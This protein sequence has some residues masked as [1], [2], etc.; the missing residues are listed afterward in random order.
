MLLAVKGKEDFLLKTDDGLQ[1]TLVTLP[2]MDR[3]YYERF[4]Y[5]YHPDYS[6]MFADQELTAVAIMTGKYVKLPLLFEHLHYSTGKTPK[7]VINS[8]NDSTWQQGERLFNERLKS[9]FG[10][11]NP[12]I[13]Y[14]EIVWR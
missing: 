5:V 14:S 12:V 13:P 11:E 7:D 2:I 10:I 9:N 8:K 4:G 3:K 6:H 1:K